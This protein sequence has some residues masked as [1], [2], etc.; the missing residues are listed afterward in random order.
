M[1]MNFFFYMP[2]ILAMPYIFTEL[3]GRLMGS[4]ISCGPRKLARIPRVKK[5]KN[6]RNIVGV[7]K[8]T[9]KPIKPRKSEKNNQKNRTV[10]KTD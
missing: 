7:F 8:K 4:D 1:E 9:E 6:M 10:K 5:K 3:A 2:V